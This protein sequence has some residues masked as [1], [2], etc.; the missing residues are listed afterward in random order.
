MPARN[1]AELVLVH[2]PLT[3]DVIWRPVA[4]ALRARGRTVSVP[5][6]TKA[7]K[8]D[9]PYY[10]KLLTA[11]AEQ[12]APCPDERPVVLVGHSGAGTLLPALGERLAAGGRPVAGTVYADAQWPHPGQSWLQAVPEDLR[13]QVRALAHDGVLPPWDEWFP[14]ETLVGALPDPDVRAWFRA[15][16]PRLPL[17]YFEERAPDAAVD[18][19]H[20]RAAYLRF[21]PAYEETAIRAEAIGHRVLRRTS[22]HLGL[23]TD[24]E[25]TADAIEKLA[26]GFASRPAD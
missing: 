14:E 8:G 5:S 20:S 11:A 19:D 1:Q 10:P 4:D 17:D 25:G 18:S 3:G 13:A 12:A 9:G 24:P 22:H 23:V 6:L 2:S 16:I 21:S 7:L 26:A 15:G